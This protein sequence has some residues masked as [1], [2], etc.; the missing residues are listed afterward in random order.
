MYNSSHSSKLISSLPPL[1]LI[2]G[3]RYFFSYID[4]TYHKESFPRMRQVSTESPCTYVTQIYLKFFFIGATAPQWVR[5]SSLMMLLDHT[6]KD[7][8]QSVGLLWTND[9]LVA[10]NSDNTQHTSIPPV[11]LEPTISAGER[12][13]TYALDRAA[14]GIDKY[15]YNTPL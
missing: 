3:F 11:E 8:P 6:H 4:I 1:R 14:T 10:E 7:A 9:Q 13:Q 12:P 5:V 15:T 2:F